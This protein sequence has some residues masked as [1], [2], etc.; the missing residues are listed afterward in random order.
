MSRSTIALAAVLAAI[1]ALTSALPNAA[2]DE[3]LDK[4]FDALK[5]Y[6]WGADRTA[7]AKSELKHEIGRASCRERV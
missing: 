7:L 2:A 1:V 3:A 6:E 5:G 4:A